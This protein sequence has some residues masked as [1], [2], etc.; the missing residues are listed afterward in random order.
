MK[1]EGVTNFRYEEFFSPSYFK[2]WKGTPYWLINSI[3]YLLPHLAQF[4]RDRYQNNAVTICN[5]LWR[6][7]N[8]YPY[9]YSGFRELECEEGSKVSRHRLG[10]CID[11][12]VANVTPQEIQL[13]VKNNF[14]QF[15]S[16]GLTAIEEDT[17]TWTHLS[18][19]DTDWRREDGLWII[20]NPNKK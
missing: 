5:W 3:D 12:K 15:N 14:L 13:D 16:R 1:I 17:P 18:V 2:K 10:K 8:D 9:D 6:A 4:I 7:K 20:P 19:E 11:I